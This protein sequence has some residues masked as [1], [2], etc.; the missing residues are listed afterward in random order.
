[1]AFR[2]APK[3]IEPVRKGKPKKEADY[4]SALHLLPCCV[5]G[6]NG[7]EAAHVSFA[8]PFYGHLGRGKGQKAAD[9][10]A[11]PVNPDDHRRQHSMGEREFW[12]AVGIDPHLLALRIHGLW[13]E[14]GDEFVP[15]AT[16]MIMDGIV[17]RTGQTPKSRW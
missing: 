4:L 2:I 7:V 14:Y 8:A 1:M 13:T 15:F 12:M 3:T 9:R 6:R 17:S 11:L 16:A 10:W 5:T